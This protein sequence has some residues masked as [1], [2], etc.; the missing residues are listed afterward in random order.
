LFEILEL[1]H[2]KVLAE[3]VLKKLMRD[4]SFWDKS[5]SFNERYMWIRIGHPP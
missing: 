1:G 2:G 5:L 3:M 4:K